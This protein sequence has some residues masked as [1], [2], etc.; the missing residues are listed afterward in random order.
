MVDFGLGVAQGVD[1]LV[2]EHHLTEKLI[3]LHKIHPRGNLLINSEFVAL[4]DI[5]VNLGADSVKSGLISDTSLNQLLSEG[6]NAVFLLPSLDF[7]LGA[8]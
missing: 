6:D 3:L 2:G 4:E 7:F 1:A 5:G 8:V